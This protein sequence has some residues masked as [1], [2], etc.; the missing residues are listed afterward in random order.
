MLRPLIKAM[1]DLERRD[2]IVM[3]GTLEM[4]TIGL[5]VGDITR[6]HLYRLG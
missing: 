4:T 2:Y 5:A 3:G 1:P 6:V